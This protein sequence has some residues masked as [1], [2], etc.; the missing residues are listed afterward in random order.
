MTKSFE[1]KVVFIR[2]VDSRQPT[3]SWQHISDIDEPSPVICV[4]VGWLL[5]DNKDCKTLCATMGDLAH[6]HPQGC[7][8]IEIP[9]KCII[10]ISDIYVS[11]QSSAVRLGEAGGHARA[12]KLSPERRSEIARK[13]ANARWRK[14]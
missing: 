7:G 2:W 11:F 6:E 1:H 4:T 8:V 5:H 9:T 12:A 10:E 3:S 13:A 14:S